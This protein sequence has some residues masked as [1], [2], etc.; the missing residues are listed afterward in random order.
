MHRPI[1]TRLVSRPN[2]SLATYLNMDDQQ[3]ACTI[4]QYK[5]I[6]EKTQLTKTAKLT[7]MIYPSHF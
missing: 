6:A 1:N 4:S 7:F 3:A 2:A 5:K